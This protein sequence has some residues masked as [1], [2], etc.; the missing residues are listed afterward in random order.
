VIALYLEG[1]KRGKAFV[2]A[3]RA[4]APHKPIVALYVGGSETGR[5]A[6]LSHTGA[7][8]GPDK[9][10]EGALLQ[11]G[12]IRARSI[13]ELFDFCW[14]FGTQPAAK[15]SRVAVLTHSGGPGA[16][17]ADACGRAGLDMPPFSDGTL[18]K[19]K[20]LLPHTA[21][22]QNPVD[23]T[24]NKNPQDYFSTIPEVLLQDE[25]MDML[26]VYVLVPAK[27]I[28][29]ALRQLGVPQEKVEAKTKK[30]IRIQTEGVANLL[31]TYGKPL[32]G[33]TYQTLGESFMRELIQLG[34]PVFPGPERAVAAMKALLAYESIKKRLAGVK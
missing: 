23:C 32:I 6:A 12:V 22:V 25:R 9:L 5:R 29:R 21:A 17:A 11:S 18:D 4:I 26:L 10:Y 30:V 7:M 16:S 34:V 33:Y 8:A 24:F 27:S 3:A 28:S 1:I 19:L 2:E 20:E 31:K 13:S 14:V 15:G